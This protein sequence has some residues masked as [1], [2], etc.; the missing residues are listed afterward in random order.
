VEGGCGFKHPG[1]RSN[2]Y[3]HSAE[4]RTR[5]L[6]PTKNK[7]SDFL[8]KAEK[9]SEKCISK[10]KKNKKSEKVKKQKASAGGGS[11]IFA[12]MF[13]WCYYHFKD[14]FMKRGLRRMK[15]IKKSICVDCHLFA[16][17]KCH[18]DYAVIY[19]PNYADASLDFANGELKN[20]RLER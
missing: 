6:Y 4:S 15:V 5:Y 18:G 17:K 8:E 10:N 12:M 2:F 20:E 1:A 3:I 16:N 13:L 7:K 14:D 9:E 19:C 11:S